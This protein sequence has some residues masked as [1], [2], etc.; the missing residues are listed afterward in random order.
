MPFLCASGRTIYRAVRASSTTMCV[1]AAATLCRSTHPWS[2][3]SCPLSLLWS[4]APTSTSSGQA[5]MQTSRTTLGTEGR[6]LTAATS[7]SSATVARQCHS[8]ST[9]TRS[10]LMRRGVQTTRRAARWWRS[11]PTWTSAKTTLSAMMSRTTTRQTTTAS[12]STLPRRTSMAAWSGWT[13][14]EST[15]LGAHATTT[16]ATARSRPL[17]ASSRPFGLGT[18]A[19]RWASAF[20]SSW[21]G[22]ST[23]PQLGTPS[24]ILLAGSFPRAT[25]PV[26]SPG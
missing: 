23:W 17:S 3:T 14:S 15:T 1:A 21:R 2:M 11:S 4:R 5:P 22:L 16:S 6:A 10:S 19:S 8:P 12:N 20:C 7:C 9:S 18:L 24:R 25:G 13:S 26:S